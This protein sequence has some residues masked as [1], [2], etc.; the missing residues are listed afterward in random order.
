MSHINS[1]FLKRKIY[2]LLPT[3]LRLKLFNYLL[4]EIKLDLDNIIFRPAQT[5]E[6]Y[7]SAFNLVYQVFLKT[8]FVQASPTPFRLAPQHCNPD[9]RVFI[10]TIPDPKKEK[11]VYSISESFDQ[12]RVKTA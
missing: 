7:L 4:P 9:S 8:G 10:G 3:V 6:D 2:K 11:L 1:N 12:L 5:P